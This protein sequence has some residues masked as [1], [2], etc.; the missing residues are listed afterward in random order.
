M[1]NYSINLKFLFH[2]GFAGASSKEDEPFE[3]QDDTKVNTSA[4]GK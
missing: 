1:C 2:F 4:K 3:D